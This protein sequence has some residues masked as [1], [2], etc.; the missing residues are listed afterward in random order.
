MIESKKNKKKYT[1]AEL[2][3]IEEA[4]NEEAARKLQAELDVESIEQIVQPRRPQTIAQQRNAMM[5]FLK[6][7]GYKG[8]QKL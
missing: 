7:Q 3:G 8:L 2:K 6:G 5:S 1:L 4:K